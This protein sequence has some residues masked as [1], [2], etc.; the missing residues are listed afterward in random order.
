M[1]DYFILLSKYPLQP[2]SKM[3]HPRGIKQYSCSICNFCNLETFCVNILL[4]A[5]WKKSENTRFQE[6]R[7]HILALMEHLNIIARPLTYTE[8]DET[9]DTTTT[10]VG[11]FL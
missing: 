7:G 8:N 2:F 10:Q 9:G 11:H 4:D 6:N 5:V 3:Q 1:A